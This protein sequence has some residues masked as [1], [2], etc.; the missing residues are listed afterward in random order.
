MLNKPAKGEPTNAA[1]P[2]NSSNNPNAFVNLL[3]PRSSTIKI[4][5]SDAKQA[6]INKSIFLHFLDPSIL[7]LYGS[8]F[9]IELTDR[10]SKYTSINYKQCM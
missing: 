6:E 4:E 3:S 7:I 10:N 5:R 9:K 1:A 2:W 8:N